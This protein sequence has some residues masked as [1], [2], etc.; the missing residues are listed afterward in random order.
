[1]V[2]RLAQP[3]FVVRTDKRPIIALAGAVARS[4][5][6]AG[7]PLRKTRDSVFGQCLMLASTIAGDPSASGD[8]LYLIRLAV[9]GI[10][11]DRGLRL[12]NLSRRRA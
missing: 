5:Q 10:E 7:I 6:A 12:V 2:T 11:R 4:L 3:K 1:M 9:E 8:Q